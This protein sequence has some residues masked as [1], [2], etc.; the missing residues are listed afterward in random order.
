LNLAEVQGGEFRCNDRKINV[1]PLAGAVVRVRSKKHH[2]ANVN[3]A[4]F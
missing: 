4:R 3:A 1:T 2:L